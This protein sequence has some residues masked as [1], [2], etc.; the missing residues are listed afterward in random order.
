MLVCISTVSTR[1]SQYRRL[2]YRVSSS[3][4][5]SAQ[6][7]AIGKVSFPILVYYTPG[8]REVGR[9]FLFHQSRVFQLLRTVLY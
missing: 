3:T 2:G 5:L 8:R 1:Y 9:M 7:N 4:R 6:Q